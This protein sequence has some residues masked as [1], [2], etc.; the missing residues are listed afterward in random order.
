MEKW[1]RQTAEQVDHFVAISQTVANRIKKIYQR[2]SD[3]IYP[4]VNCSFYQPGKSDGDYFLI[5]SR[6]NAYK[7]IDLAVEVFNQLGLPLKIIGQGPDA[8]RLKRLA[9]D[10]IEFL[11]K[12]PDDEVAKSL[13]ECRAL[14]FPGEEDFGIVPVEA[15]SA[16]RPVVAFASG[17]A[18]ETVIDGQ[19]GLFFEEATAK[20]L[21]QALKRFQ[22]FM[23]R[24]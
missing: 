13:A 16:G 18:K 10:N 6:L 20:S 7:R 24:N 19:T 5:V 3:I 9:K 12:L 17:G 21:T 2:E 23:P 8:G 14:I 11:G 22:I 1:D 4:P 15:M